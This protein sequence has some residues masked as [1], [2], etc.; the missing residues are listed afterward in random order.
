MARRLQ[1]VRHSGPMRHSGPARHHDSAQRGGNVSAPQALQNRSAS[2]SGVAFGSG[3]GSVWFPAWAW[4][5]FAI[6]VAACGEPT[7]DAID[8]PPGEWMASGGTTGAPSGSRGGTGTHQDE[9]DTGGTQPGGSGNEPRHSGGDSSESSGGSENPYGT[10]GFGWGS[11][12]YYATGGW[13]P[14]TGGGGNLW[15]S[16]GSSSGGGHTVWSGGQTGWS[17]GGGSSSTPSSCPQFPRPGESCSLA[18]YTPSCRYDVQGEPVFCYCNADVWSCYWPC[19]DR[20]ESLSNCS[21]EDA[22]CRYEDGTLCYCA[23]DPSSTTFL[24]WM[25]ADTTA[26]GGAGAPGTAG[27]AGAAG[28]AGE[29]AIPVAPSS[30]PSSTQP[31]GTPCKD[32]YGL[33]TYCDYG[34]AWCMCTPV[35]WHCEYTNRNAQAT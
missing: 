19:Q 2:L 34:H 9:S 29:S 5:T 3:A 17:T 28:V 13:G 12:G 30:C 26:Q 31:G 15:P 14:F 11:G 20:P 1:P 27:A 21:F 33:Q 16:G 10:G 18:D 22:T 32:E 23:S 24:R 35:G 25:C 6:S 7:L 8:P 4:L